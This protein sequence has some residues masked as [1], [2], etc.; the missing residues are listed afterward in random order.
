MVEQDGTDLSGVEISTLRGV[1]VELYTA[2]PF[3]TRCSKKVGL[4]CISAMSDRPARLYAYGYGA[5]TREL[6]VVQRT[7]VAL[8]EWG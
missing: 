6:P 4:W 7:I 3:K 8:T 5:I 1:Q 2:L